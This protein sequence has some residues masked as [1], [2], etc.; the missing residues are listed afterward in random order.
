MAIDRTKLKQIHNLLAQNGFAQDYSTFEKKFAGNAN[1]GNRKKV[2]DLITENGGDIGGSYEDFMKRLQSKPKPK[3]QPSKP[4]TTSQ[5]AM[6]M[7]GRQL[8]KP[9]NVP[10]NA[11]PFVQSL[12]A[13]DMAE[14]GEQQPTD[15]VS[16]REDYTSPKAVQNM[17]RRSQ[18][19]GRVAA[20]NAA[21]EI[22][23]QYMQSQPVMN[24]GTPAD[25]YVG[26]TER[27]LEKQY[28]R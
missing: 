9:K 3:Q 15:Y 7:G 21:A 27:Q 13:K 5:R 6:Q 25:E 12:Y 19:A 8:P 22:D 14:R 24:T 4:Q 11:S 17:S 18:K 28:I 2:Y 16:K 26:K 1:Y 10:S 23:E 20:K